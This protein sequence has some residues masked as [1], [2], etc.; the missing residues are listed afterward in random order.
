MHPDAAD[1]RDRRVIFLLVLMAQFVVPLGLFGLGALAPLLRTAL[2]LSREQFGY[3]SALCAIGAACACIPTGW[4]ADRVGVRE[5]LVAGQVGS[6]LALAAL[7]LWP[8]YGMLLLAMLLVGVA[9]GATMV[10]TTKALVDWFPREHRATVMGAKFVTM[11]GAGSVAGVA[12]PSLALALGWHQAFATVGSLLLASAIGVLLGY[13]DR[14]QER[15]PTTP[16]LA[17]ASRRLRH[18]RH[19]WRL[20]TV[21]FLFGGVFF[22]FTAYL[23]L[24][25]HERLGYLPVLSGGLLALAHGAATASRVPYG[26]VS[27]RWLRGERRVLL[28]GMAVVATGALLAL[29]L[30]PPG[31]PVPALAM[32]IL[33]YGASGLA[34]GGLYQTLAAE[35]AGKDAQGLGAGL[36]TTLVQVGSTV[37]PPVFG[38]LVDITGSYAVGWGLLML[39]LL[40]AIGLLGPARNAPAPQEGH[41]APPVLVATHS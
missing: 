22:G 9:H 28:R 17:A 36:A 34:W 11:S 21:G 12:L 8:T 13:R 2:Q 5:L 23:T 41:A 1:I 4:L 29:V 30:L 26:W 16:Q 3:V 27:D 37:T 31:T 40:G 18:D 25:L 14:C 6:G 19:F 35:R 39:L 33:L 24:Y 38:A 32:V 10:L 15:P 7:L 20:V